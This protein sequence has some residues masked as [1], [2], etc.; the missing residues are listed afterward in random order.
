[1]KG[2]DTDKDKRGGARSQPLLRGR[3]PRPRPPRAAP[4]P[5]RRAP[6]YNNVNDQATRGALRWPKPCARA[7]GQALHV[8][9]HLRENREGGEGGGG[10]GRDNE[11][12][13]DRQGGR[14]AD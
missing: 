7:R 4:S 8:H 14:L 13:A 1:M 3:C 10:R 5:L 11:R 2:N 12:Q 6:R 9:A